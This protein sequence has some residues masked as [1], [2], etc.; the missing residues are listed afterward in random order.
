V[1]S[2]NSPTKSREMRGRGTFTSIQVKSPKKKT[3]ILSGGQ[4]RAVQKDSK[5]RTED[6]TW[7]HFG[8]EI[9]ND[10]NILWVRR[11]RDTKP[12]R[13]RKKIARDNWRGGSTLAKV[14]LRWP[15]KRKNVPSWGRNPKEWKKN[16]LTCVIGNLTFRL[17]YLVGCFRT[18]SYYSP[19]ERK[20]GR[21][22]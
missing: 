15:Q 22:V 20:E 4:M 16:G 8:Q 6:S 1:R 2:E 18:R 11:K 13:T 19:V 3:N 17:E 5:K 7:K 9:L 14:T 10:W 21:T 12:Y